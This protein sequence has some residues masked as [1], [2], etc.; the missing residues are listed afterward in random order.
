MDQKKQNNDEKNENTYVKT[1][2]LKKKEN[3]ERQKMLTNR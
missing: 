2:N 1:R 3:D